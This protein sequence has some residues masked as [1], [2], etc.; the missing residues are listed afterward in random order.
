MI[1]VT[2]GAQMPFD[3]LV[4]WIDLNVPDH[5][6]WGAQ[7]DVPGDYDQKRLAMRSRYANRPENPEQVA[8]PKPLASGD[9]RQL[10]FSTDPQVHFLDP[11]YVPDPDDASGDHLDRVCLAMVSNLQGEWCASSPEGILGEAEEGRPPRVPAH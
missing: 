7:R 8:E 10:T 9:A 11:L 5:G 3:R 4:T 1:F 2:V 6:S